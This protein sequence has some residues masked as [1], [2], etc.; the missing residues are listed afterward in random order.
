MSRFLKSSYNILGVD[1]GEVNT[2][3]A[4][5]VDGV[6][7]PLKIVNSKNEESYIVHQYDRFGFDDKKKISVKYNFTI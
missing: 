5:S 6:S 7:A 4:V 2:G 3:F 1:Y